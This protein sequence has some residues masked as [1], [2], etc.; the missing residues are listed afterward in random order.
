MHKVLTPLGVIRTPNGMLL[1]PVEG[2][3]WAN[4][5]AMV[6]GVCTVY[7]CSSQREQPYIYIHK[8]EMLCLWSLACSTVHH[9][10]LSRSGASRATCVGQHE[11][12]LLAKNF[13]WCVS[14][15]GTCAGFVW[16]VPPCE[17]VAG[18]LENRDPTPSLQQLFPQAVSSPTKCPGIPYSIILVGINIMCHIT[19]VRVQLCML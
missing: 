6:V 3:G 14:R 17:L 9:S 13:C 18:G 19:P 12:F 16:G 4:V 10:L 8:K 15:C 2:A 1:R 5:Y 7:T 11:T